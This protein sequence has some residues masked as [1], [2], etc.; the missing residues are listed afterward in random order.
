MFFL[1]S[2]KEKISN[3]DNHQ[4]NNDTIKELKQ[5][6]GEQAGFVDSLINF[7]GI[8]PDVSYPFV[9]IILP[10]NYC[11]PCKIDVTR[12]L[13]DLF[14]KIQ[15]LPKDNILIITEKMRKKEIPLYKNEDYPLDNWDSL[16]LVLSDDWGVRILKRLDLV[17]ASMF[18]T[19]TTGKVIFKKQFKNTVEYFDDVD[20]V[21]SII[22]AKY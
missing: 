8:K 1:F 12:Y 21:A 15:G 10:V 22:N 14:S 19:D 16:N 5:F 2:C 20:N 13:N 17:G 4:N 9:C 18:V 11:E 6:Y 7:A 3:S